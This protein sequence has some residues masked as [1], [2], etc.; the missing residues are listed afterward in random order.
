MTERKKE[1]NYKQ[2]AWETESGMVF[3]GHLK[4]FT[5]YKYMTYPTH[6]EI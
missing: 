3:D 5:N 6:M 1:A 4:D 2:G